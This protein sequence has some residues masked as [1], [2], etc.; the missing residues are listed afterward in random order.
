MEAKNGEANDMR[1]SGKEAREEGEPSLICQTPGSR[2][3]TT[4]DLL[5][6]LGMTT[7]PAH[8]RRGWLKPVTTRRPAQPDMLAVGCMEKC[9]SGRAGG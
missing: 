7:H 1:S 8:L 4:A 5:E 3:E 2:Q 9:T 6:T